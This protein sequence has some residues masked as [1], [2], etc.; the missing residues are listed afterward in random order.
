[1]AP[2]VLNLGGC[3]VGFTLR[4]HYAQGKSQR[5]TLT[6]RLNESCT[7][8]VLVNRSAQTLLVSP[9]TFLRTVSAKSNLIKVCSFVSLS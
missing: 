8:V 7:S 5:Y 9:F 2:L 6:R 3:V 1:M 4:P